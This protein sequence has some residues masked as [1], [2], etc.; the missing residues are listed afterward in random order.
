[1]TTST[2]TTAGP[3][4]TR[5]LVGAACL[6]T[7]FLALLA[8]G[9]FDPFDDTARPSAQ[10][11]Q[12]P[13]HVADMR[14]LGWIEIA[15]AVLLA[16]VTLTFAGHTRGRGR[17]LGNAGVVLGCIGVAGMTL[18]GVHHWLMGALAGVPHTTAAHVLDRLDTIAG[19]AVLLMFLAAPLAVVLF[20]AAGHRAGFVPLPALGLMVA[21]LAGEIVPLPGG[22][23]APLVIALIAYAWIAVTL[24]GSACGVS[25]STT[26]VAQ[27]QAA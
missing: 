2:I 27:P 5:L 11:A 20:A 16:G 9:L 1:M 14:P 4:R 21:F 12:L 17:G 22:E 3:S 15:A 24:V 25:P 8:T 13:G 10:L 23:L 19:P 18:Q 7:F 26:A 6:P